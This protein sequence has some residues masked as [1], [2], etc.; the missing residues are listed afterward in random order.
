MPGLGPKMVKCLQDNPREI[1]IWENVCLAF[2]CPPLSTLLILWLKSYYKKEQNEVIFSRCKAICAHYQHQGATWVHLTPA[3]SIFYPITQDDSDTEKNSAQYCKLL[4][5]KAVIYISCLVLVCLFFSVCV[6][7]IHPPRYMY[8]YFHLYENIYLYIY[9]Y[10]SICLLQKL[11][12]PKKMN[13]ALL[14]YY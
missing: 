4:T 14:F 9:R 10:S 3:K 2:I 11:R 5:P 8:M 12:C 13:A 7:T 6:L 1:T